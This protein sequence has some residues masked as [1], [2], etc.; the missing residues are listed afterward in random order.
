ME[1]CHNVRLATSSWASLVGL[2]APLVASTTLM[3]QCAESRK[4]PQ[5]RTDRAHILIGGRRSTALIGSIAQQVLTSQASG[6]ALVPSFIALR[7][8]C[9]AL[10]PFRPR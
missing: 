7:R 6:E 8:D 9:V 4:D 2:L 10:S 5:T 3:L 1:A